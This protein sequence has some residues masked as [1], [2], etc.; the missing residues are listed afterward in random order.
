[1]FLSMLCNVVVPVLV[2]KVCQVISSLLGL[3]SQE[4]LNVCSLVIELIC[5]DESSSVLT[6]GALIH[7]ALLIHA[8]VLTVHAF[9]TT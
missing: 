4:K 5:I 9:G 7:L 2:L 1:M 3:M 8:L 6:R